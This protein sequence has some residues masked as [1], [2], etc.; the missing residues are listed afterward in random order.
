MLRNFCLD[1]GW[2]LGITCYA[3]I[4][5]FSGELFVEFE[6]IE[7]AEKVLFLK[8]LLQMIRMLRPFLYLTNLM[9][10]CQQ[11]TNKKRYKILL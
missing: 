11:I 6:P 7:E 9:N 5:G 1:R 3:I 8:S 10:K 2:Q 4:T